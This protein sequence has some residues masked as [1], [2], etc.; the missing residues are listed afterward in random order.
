MWLEGSYRF[1]SL[2][3]GGFKFLVFS[4]FLACLE[5]SDIVLDGLAHARPPEA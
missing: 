3:K 5:L 1:P 2:S 4:S